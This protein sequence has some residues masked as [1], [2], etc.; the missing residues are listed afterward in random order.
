[1]HFIRRRIAKIKTCKLNTA[2]IIIQ[3]IFQNKFMM[4]FGGITFLSCVS[5]ICYMKYQYKDQ[6]VYTAIDDNN[7]LVLTKKRSGWD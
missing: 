4:W 7:E 1:M 3:I 5:Y 2:A 6:K